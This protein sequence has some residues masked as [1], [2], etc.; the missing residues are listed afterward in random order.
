VLIEQSITTSSLVHLGPSEQVYGQS[1]HILV[2][3]ALKHCL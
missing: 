2:Q 1:G 3:R